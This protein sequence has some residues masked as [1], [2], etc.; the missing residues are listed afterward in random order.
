VDSWINKEKDEQHTLE[1]Q[2]KLDHAFN[3]NRHLKISLGDTQTNIALLKAE[4]GQM[5]S[6]YDTK[7][8]ELNRLLF[9]PYV[10]YSFLP[11]I[12]FFESGCIRKH[13]HIFYSEREQRMEYL[14]AVDNLTR[15]LDLLR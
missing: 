15:Q 8:A 5:R 4:F 6:Q 10:T 14:Y 9:I 2:K 12:K 11:N 7:C 1:A 13:C 3:E